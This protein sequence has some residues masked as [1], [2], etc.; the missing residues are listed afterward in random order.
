MQWCT[1]CHSFAPSWD[2]VAT[3]LNAGTRSSGLV[4]AL[5]DCEKNTRH[6]EVCLAAGVKAYPTVMYVGS[7]EIR[8]TDPLTRLA[9]G[10]DRSAGPFGASTLRR[11]VKFQGNWQYA[12]Q[13]LDWVSMMGGMS[14]WHAMAETGPLRGLRDGMLRLITGGKYGGARD[15]NGV[16][17]GN[18][19]SLPVGV[20]PDFQAGLRRTDLAAAGTGAAGAKEIED[21]RTELNATADEKKLYERA[22]A[23]SGHLIEGLLFSDAGSAAAAP[24]DPFAILTD[25]GGWHRNST[26]PAANAPR[27][28]HPSILRS[29][30]LEQSIDYCDRVARRSTDA[31]I[32]ELAAIPESDPFPTLEEIEARLLD[33][34]RGE[35]PFCGALEGCIAGDFED[36]GCRVAGCPFENGAA[37]R[38]VESCLDPRIQDE[39]GVGLGGPIVRCSGM[40][41]RAN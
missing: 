40:G 13:V 17:A 18:G 34:V 37:C 16:A 22:V 32:A 39:Y 27:D 19:E 41:C 12:D 6:A 14:R 9:L 23:H 2:A 29:C 7:G 20:P 35:E 24:R 36:A 11:T 28:E 21:L 1:N 33:D 30:A 15:R 5:F 10:R 4:M 38:Y 31:Y 8:D 3:H 25:S 26:A